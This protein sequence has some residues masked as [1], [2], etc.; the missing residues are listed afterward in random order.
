MLEVN[1][2]PKDEILEKAK[3]LIRA[4][5]FVSVMDVSGGGSSQKEE[6][7]ATIETLRR[8]LSER[9]YQEL[10]PVFEHALENHRA[11][12]LWGS[13][14]ADLVPDLRKISKDLPLVYRQCIYDLAYCVATRYRER[15]WLMALLASMRVSLLNF[16]I[17]KDSKIDLPLYLN[18]SRLERS[19]LNEL[20]DVLSLPREIP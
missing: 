15:N 4:A 6:R 8:F 20:S 5:S 13:N 19:A 14:L 3:L 17:P 16:L 7:K 1:Q 11:W 9:D 10:Y 12:N 2:E 18:I